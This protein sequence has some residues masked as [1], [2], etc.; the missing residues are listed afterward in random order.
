MTKNSTSSI[1]TNAL[2]SVPTAASRTIALHALRA[3]DSK[4]DN[5]STIALALT[6]GDI[7]MG[8]ARNSATR[9]A[10]HAPTLGMSASSVQVCTKE[11][12]GIV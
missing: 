1:S 12:E 5:A 8:Y 4:M 9:N 3:I 2:T 11:R 7:K 6:T 10:G